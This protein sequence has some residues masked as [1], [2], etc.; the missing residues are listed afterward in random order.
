[1]GRK[2]FKV[3]YNITPEYDGVGIESAE[4]C[5]TVVAK[6]AVGAMAAANFKATKPLRYFD[7]DA[8]K[9][10]KVTYRHF[11]PLEIEHLVD[12]D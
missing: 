1:M 11:E 7:D 2:V 4:E 9:W 8:R 5:K 10:V 3:K 6:N 12:L